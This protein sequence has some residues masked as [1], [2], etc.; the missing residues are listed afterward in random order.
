[1]RRAKPQIAD[2]DPQLWE[3]DFRTWIQSDFVPVDEYLSA[4]ERRCYVLRTGTGDICL[5]RT[6]KP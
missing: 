5:L 6:W 1:M 4:L 2:I 3:H